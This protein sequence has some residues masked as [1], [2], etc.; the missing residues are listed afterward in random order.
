M[1]VSIVDD[2]VIV[3]EATRDLL[4]AHGYGAAA[5][6]SAALF[7][8]SGR[9]VETF[10]LIT[11][12][13]MPGMSGFELRRRL[14]AAGYDIPTIFITAQCDDGVR[15]HARAAGA[16]AFLTKPCREQYLLRC[17]EAAIRTPGRPPRDAAEPFNIFRPR[18]ALP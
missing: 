5:F 8:T 14:V 13:A 9:I 12:V 7:L 2:D 1:I 10:C 17:V 3:G 16:H 4:R 6:A 15:D 11:D 18:S